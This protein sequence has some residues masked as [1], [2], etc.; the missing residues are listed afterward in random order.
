MNDS[1]LVQQL[2]FE[3]RCNQALKDLAR[4]RNERL[5]L[6]Q[7]P[8]GPNGYSSVVSAWPQRL[9]SGQ[10]AKSYP[11]MSRRGDSESANFR[12]LQSV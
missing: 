1:P 6:K 12:F 7:L 4:S 3:K 11:K 5:F 9:L 2:C 8:Q 10:L